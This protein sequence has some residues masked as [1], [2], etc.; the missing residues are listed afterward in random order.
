MDVQFILQ[1]LNLAEKVADCLIFAWYSHLVVV[2][3][4]LHELNLLEA[5]T[6]LLNDLETI[7]LSET[8]LHECRHTYKPVVH[9]CLEEQV[10]AD[11]ILSQLVN[12]KTFNRSRL[13][14]R[15]GIL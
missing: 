14:H 5:A 15:L 3:T 10:R 8:E 12:N 7:L 4:L 6:Q 11:A 1:S 9:A 13:K 2:A